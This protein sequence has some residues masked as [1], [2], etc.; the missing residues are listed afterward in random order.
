MPPSR[1][2]TDP[3][4]LPGWS[5]DDHA[6]ALTAYALTVDQ[7]PAHWPRPD[8]SSA[9]GFLENHFRC[10]APQDALVT[11]YYEP[12]LNGSA[13]ETPRFRFPLHALPPMDRTPWFTRAE[14][15]EGRRLRGRELVWLDDPLEAFL[16]QVQGSVRL[17]LPDGS[18][19]RLGYA[20]RNGHPYRSIGAE[21]VARGAVS[22]DA[23]STEA[24]R[25]WARANP[26]QLDGLLRCNP[27]YVF[28]RTLD[29]HADLGPLGALGTTV[30]S[31]RSVAADPAVP[32][33]A[34]VWLAGAGL[35]RLTVVHD[36]GSAITGSRID[37][38]CGTGP[39]AGDLASG[40]KIAA[41]TVALI[42]KAWS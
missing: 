16:A 26:D 4:S 35:N 25:D 1:A 24:I 41:R 28:F 39:S 6:A 15:Q 34:L 12:E 7:L 23:I 21:L 30:L 11:G 13:V 5:E 14:I 42:P 10:L 36:R 19:L 18:V 9:R 40:M 22:A 27:S 3:A 38:F 32:G 37:L 8:G 2:D 20:G 29:L 33:G 17:R 31:G